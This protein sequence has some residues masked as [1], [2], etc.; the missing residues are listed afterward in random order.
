MK[1]ISK[2]T[3]DTAKIAEFLAK[4]IKPGKSATVVALSGELGAG[5]THLTQHTAKLFG[6]KKKL[7]SPTFVIMKFYDL[8]GKDFKKFI[9]ID[10][11][12]LKN[13]DE[14]LKLGWKE[15]IKDP[16]NLIFIEW[17]ENVKSAMPKNPIK[18]S[19]LHYEKD[20]RKISIKF[21]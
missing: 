4:K 11:Y 5:K 9:H 21:P 10:A 3:E 18:I 13:A 1:Y 20:S 8:K 12:R 19:I 7:A 14:L 16:E 15:M 17:P 2:N 6:I